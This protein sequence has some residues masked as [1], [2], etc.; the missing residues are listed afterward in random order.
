VVAALVTVREAERTA[1]LFQNQVRPAAE[2]LVDTA[3]QAYANG[4]GSF[5]GLIDD[6]RMVLE[7]RLLI[8]EARIEREKSLDDLEALLAMDI[9]SLPSS[10]LSAPQPTTAPM[11]DGAEVSHVP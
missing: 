5:A 2:S 4:T 8:A 9:E 10:P 6:E 7:V 1:R 11:S 3:H